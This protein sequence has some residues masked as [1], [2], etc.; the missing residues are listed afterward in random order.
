ML[1][2]SRFQ[3][4]VTRI[5]L[6]PLIIEELHWYGE[7]FLMV[8]NQLYVSRFSDL[9]QDYTCQENMEYE[10]LRRRDRE[11]NH[12]A[13]SKLLTYERELKNTAGMHCGSKDRL[14]YQ[15]P[16]EKLSCV[17][18]EPPAGIEEEA[19]LREITSNVGVLSN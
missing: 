2:F 3:K 10:Q 13:V 17:C 12:T 15:A 6:F 16:S 1:P 8:L 14:I 11:G 19:V 5:T 4:V 7:N 9:E 18:H